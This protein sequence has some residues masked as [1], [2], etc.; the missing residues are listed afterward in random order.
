M[1][2]AGTP[3]CVADPEKANHRHDVRESLS[4]VDVVEDRCGE[5][6]GSDDALSHDL[7]DQPGDARTP[8]TV[9]QR[10]RDDQGICALEEVAGHLEAF[11]VGL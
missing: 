8:G 10:R 4:G 11:A 5:A 2:G 9:F 1:P 3:G 6:D 7:F